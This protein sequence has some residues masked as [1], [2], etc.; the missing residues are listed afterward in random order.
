[1]DG[2][3]SHERAAQG[4]T[5]CSSYLVRYQ[6]AE[7]GILIDIIP[8][9]HLPPTTL[10]LVIRLYSTVRNATLVALPSTL[11]QLLR[12]P[13]PFDPSILPPSSCK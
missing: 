2:R 11:Q 12:H 9:Y 3:P 10:L 4:L 1:M 8:S 13:F 6:P 7:P 5:V